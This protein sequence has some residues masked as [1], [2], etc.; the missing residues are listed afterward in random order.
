MSKGHPC[1]VK[2]SI[3]RVDQR[4]FQQMH[5]TQLQYWSEQQDTVSCCTKR[6]E[7]HLVEKNNLW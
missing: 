4:W 6:Q 3:V 2:T 1:P 7:N 5:D